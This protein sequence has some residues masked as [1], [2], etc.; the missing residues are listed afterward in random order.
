MRVATDTMETFFDSRLD[1]LQRNLAK[2]SDRLKM[3]ADQ[4]LQE[5][6][7]KDRL[8][9]RSPSGEVLTDNLDR[10]LRKFK[11]KVRRRVVFVGPL[12]LITRPGVPTPDHAH[13][14]L[15]IHQ[16]RPDTRK[17]HV[18]LWCHVSSLYRSHVWNLPR[19]RFVL[20]P[21]IPLN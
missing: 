17:D 7:K 10:E 1:L 6:F 14:L 12:T 2:H 18:F 13:R 4:A 8:K 11:L 20:S 16:S 19:V 21:N 9:V 5:M 15:A 3:K